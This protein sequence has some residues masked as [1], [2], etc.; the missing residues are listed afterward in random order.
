MVVV[1]DVHRR[2]CDIRQQTFPDPVSSISVPRTDGAP[3][4]CCPAQC[5]TSDTRHTD[6]NQGGRGL[7]SQQEVVL[8]PDRTQNHFLQPHL[9]IC[10][11]HPVLKKTERPLDKNKRSA[12]QKY[13]TIPPF[14]I[15]KKI[16]SKKL[17]MHVKNAKRR[18]VKVS[19]QQS[20]A[21]SKTCSDK[22]L[23]QRESIVNLQL[24]KVNLNKGAN[25]F[26]Y[27][28]F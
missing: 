11:T 28:A 17:R 8:G 12:T 4:W 27:K 23:L 10:D 5:L 9:Q 13:F 19:R 21:S 18:E 20:T 25:T 3:C 24:I 26:F 22:E 6:L 16:K 15:W 14:I 2:C 7:A 1:T